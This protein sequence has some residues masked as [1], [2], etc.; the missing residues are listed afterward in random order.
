MTIARYISHYF[1]K[2]AGPLLN[3][4]NLDRKQRAEIINREKDA[5]TGFNRYAHGEEFFDFRELAD[6]L[7]IEVYQRKF[8]MKPPR[9]PFYGVLGD[10]DVVG[11]LYRNPRKIKIPI[12]EFA[13]HE[14]TFM[15][16]D[17]FHLV[18][19]L[20][21]SEG[22][23]FGYQIPEDYSESLHPYF[24]KL[25]TY[26]ELVESFQTLEIDIYLKRHRA[27]NHWYRYVEAQ[28]WSDP[29]LLNERYAISYEVSSESYTINGVTYANHCLPR[30][31]E[32]DTA[33]QSA[34]AE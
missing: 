11:G 8:G 20:S 22:R 25:L 29:E 19:F 18:S 30:K 32:Q 9:R 34:T 14:V 17:H 10:A 27:E 12:E 31:A 26:Q 13:E 28:I 15:C 5:D 2:E 16:P 1:E 23:M 4:C 6:D 21:R 7:L 24:G 3:I 33:G